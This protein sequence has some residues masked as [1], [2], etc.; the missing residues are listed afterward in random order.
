MALLLAVKDDR[1][2]TS[3]DEG[4]TLTE[5]KPTARFLHL[6]PSLLLETDQSARL[7]QKKARL[8]VAC[9]ELGEAVTPAGGAV[10][11]KAFSNRR[12]RVGGSKFTERGWL[13]PLPGGRKALKSVHLVLSWEVPFE[14]KPEAVRHELALSFVGTAKRGPSVFSLDV[15]AWRGLP[16]APAILD[17]EAPLSIAPFATLDLPALQVMR[18]VEVKREDGQVV[19]RERL[20]VPAMPLATLWNLR[21]LGQTVELEA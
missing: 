13:L 17:S 18:D 6:L 9:A 5:P 20:D 11:R 4:R 19:L 10:V 8:H 21:L 16:D 2:F 3:A 14:A 7:G 1:L 12:Y 15:A